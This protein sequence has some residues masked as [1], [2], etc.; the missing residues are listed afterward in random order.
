MNLIDEIKGLAHAQREEV[1]EW[2]RWMHRHPELS[3][4]E[5]G[6]MAFVAE[7]LREMGLEPRT[8]VGKTGVTAM[9]EG[10]GR[11]TEFGVRSSEFGGRPYTV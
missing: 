4:E 6:T 2:R 5:Y 11:R 8:G 9:L 10:G 7:R 1:I 3:Q